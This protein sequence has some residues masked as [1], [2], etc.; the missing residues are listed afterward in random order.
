MEPGLEPV[1]GHLP[2]DGVQAVLDLPGQQAPPLR[3]PC[4][5]QEALEDQPLAEDGGGLRQGQGRVRQQGAQRGAEA[6][7]D[8]VAQLMG[9]G[10][11][12]PALAHVVQEDIGMVRRDHRVGIGS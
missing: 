10:Q 4:L 1:E 6:L 12:I 3:R 9:Q 7:V 8:S 11:D 5:R 2:D